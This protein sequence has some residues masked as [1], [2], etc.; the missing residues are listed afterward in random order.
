MP[1]VQTQYSGE[2]EPV[3][4]DRPTLRREMTDQ[5][6]TEELQADT[7][8]NRARRVLSE[9]LARIEHA[10]QDPGAATP[11]TTGRIEFAAVHDIVAALGF[12]VP[13]ARSA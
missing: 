12:S 4:S 7:S 5:E 2:H 3:G 6:V 13:K 1:P 11:I 8:L 10:R 9:A